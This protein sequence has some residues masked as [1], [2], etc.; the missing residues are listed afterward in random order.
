MALL[1]T[2]FTGYIVAHYREAIALENYIIATI[3][4]KSQYFTCHTAPLTSWLEHKPLVLKCQHEQHHSSVRAC[5][6]ENK[7]ISL[8][9]V[10][11][12][13]KK[14]DFPP[15]TTVVHSG[16]SSL[17]HYV[18]WREIITENWLAGLLTWPGES[19]GVRSS[20]AR[21][22]SSPRHRWQPPAVVFCTAQLTATTSHNIFS[23]FK[24]CVS[25]VVRRLYSVWAQKIVG[26]KNGVGNPV[27]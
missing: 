21:G 15:Q 9:G 5:A 4:P 23:T 11:S 3:A 20:A 24:L 22:E 26:W 6:T 8:G 25:L 7:F 16:S 12:V 13:L 19:N 27:G 18:E 17:Y 10:F 1:G 14:S 2:Q